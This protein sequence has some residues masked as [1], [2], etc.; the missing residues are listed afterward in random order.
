MKELKIEANLVG[1]LSY[2]VL[3]QSR[4]ALNLPAH[5][6]SSILKQFAGAERIYIILRNSGRLVGSLYRVRVSCPVGFG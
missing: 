1:Q 5:L 6:S 2:S 4:I 3:L